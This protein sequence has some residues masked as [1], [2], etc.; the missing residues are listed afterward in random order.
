MITM[1]KMTTMMMWSEKHRPF[2]KWWVT[3]MLDLLQ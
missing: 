3:R 1:K 2:K